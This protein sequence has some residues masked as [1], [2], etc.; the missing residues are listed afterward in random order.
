M[1]GDQ[2]MDVVVL[3]V[4]SSADLEVDLPEEEIELS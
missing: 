4:Q 3:G 1:A 2:N